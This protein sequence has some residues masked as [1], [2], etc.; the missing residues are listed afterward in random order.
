LC[1]TYIPPNEAELQMEY[2]LDNEFDLLLVAGYQKVLKLSYVDKFLS[3][4]HLEIR[5]RYKN[6]LGLLEKIQ[7]FHF[8]NSGFVEIVR[9]V[10]EEC[11][12]SNSK[13]GKTMRSFEESQKSKKSVASMIVTKNGNETEKI[14]TEPQQ[15][16]ADFEPPVSKLNKSPRPFS[17]KNKKTKSPKTPKETG[18]KPRTWEL[19][20]SNKDIGELDRTDP[21]QREEYVD[22]ENK[23]IIGTMRGNIK[24]LEE[25]GQTAK[26]K[27]SKLFG[28]F[29]GIVGGK[30]LSEE[31]VAPVVEKMRDHL[32]SKN[33]AAD[34]AYKLCDSVAT[35]IIGKTLSSF[36][37]VSSTVRSAL[38]ESIL[39][40]LKPKRQVDVLREIMEA[41]KHGRPYVITFCGVNGVGKS[42][43]LAKVR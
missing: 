34:V 1:G 36:A 4:M 17:N 11:S 23:H 5:D 20:G 27:E 37:T 12:M 33:V 18:K 38:E 2:K 21:N 41:N 9:A 29:K 6:D 7:A 39:N 10:E 13:G 32:I 25:A 42:T 40:L 26:P 22:S 30:V 15:W 35:K 3:A 19:G 14:L 8:L 31:E 43:N 24:A 16:L 28:L